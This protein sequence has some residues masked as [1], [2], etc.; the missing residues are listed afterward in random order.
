MA[1]FGLFKSKDDK[2]REEFA[3]TILPLIYPPKSDIEEIDN[4]RVAKI[5]KNK[6]TP[7][8]LKGFVAGCKARIFLAKNY[9]EISLIKSIISR[10]EGKLDLLEAYEVHAYLAG[11][12]L[13]IT[14]MVRKAHENSRR[15]IADECAEFRDYYKGAAFC[16]CR[17]EGYGKFGLTKT[18]PIPT[19]SPVSSEYYLN[20]LRFRGSPISFERVSSQKSGNL[21]GFVDQYLIAQNGSEICHIY[22]NPY[23]K[24]TS[25]LPPAGFELYGDNRLGTVIA[26]IL[27]PKTEV[28]RRELLKLD[29]DIERGVAEKLHNHGEI[30]VI[31]SYNGGKANST[32]V[33]N[34][35]WIEAK[36]SFDRIENDVK[37]EFNI[38]RDTIRQS[39]QTSFSKPDEVP[40]TSQPKK[41]F[42]YNARF[43]ISGDKVINL[44]GPQRN[45]NQVSSISASQHLNESS[46]SKP[47]SK[48][49]PIPPIQIIN[50]SGV[51]WVFNLE[52][53]YEGQKL[54]LVSEN[55]SLEIEAFGFATMVVVAKINGWKGG[56]A[57]FDIHG[58][59]GVLR[60]FNN[61]QW[62]DSNEA[63]ELPICLKSFFET[64]S[65]EANMMTEN[66]RFF[67]AFVALCNDGGFRIEAL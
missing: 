37:S 33:P 43:D 39:E 4:D 18:N 63:A 53:Y 3:N 65:S 25:A 28:V 38:I 35:M 55:I 8:R 2:S 56:Q 50:K 10:S 31:V 66:P 24:K 51:N 21:N 57:L 45:Q 44:D 48:S 54:R 6:I 49:T 60:R 41:S 26:N 9:D 46:S 67:N 17:I 19:I 7:D 1:F 11:E 13:A 16:D 62:L 59:K 34:S 22:I 58:D 30:F 15:E 12:S 64:Y 47:D 61:W 27:D 23:Q 14:L 5:T 20:S 52:N 29:Y 40:C 32:V 36:A 42:S